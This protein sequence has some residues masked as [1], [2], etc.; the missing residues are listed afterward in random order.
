[1]LF[2]V[3]KFKITLGSLVIQESDLSSQLD[4]LPGGRQSR[5]KRQNSETVFE[6]LVKRVTL[7]PYLP[8]SKLRNIF[9][10]NRKRTE[11]N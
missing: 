8:E 11:E 2:T 10:L 1:M 9:L 5:F 7:V 3:C 4:F 6:K